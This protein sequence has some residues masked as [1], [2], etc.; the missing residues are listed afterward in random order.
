MTTTFES[1][2]TSFAQLR[3]WSR[4]QWW[5]AGVA[6]AIMFVAMGEVG[7][8][9]PPFSANRTYPIEWWNYVTLVADSAVMGLVLGTFV[10]SGSKRLASASGGGF[11]ATVGAIAM[12]CPVCSPLAIPLLGAGGVLSFLRGDR[13]WL[14]LATI[15]VLGLTLI[16][17]LRASAS[18][19]VRFKPVAVSSAQPTR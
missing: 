19:P 16:L 9:L 8:T 6:F 4:T 15:L 1:L 11:A 12:A 5:I 10:T 13:G 18:C 2:R 14:A 3:W 17:R 7:Q